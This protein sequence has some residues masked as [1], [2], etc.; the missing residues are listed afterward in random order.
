M[1][2]PVP[3]LDPFPAQKEA[4]MAAPKWFTARIR[5][6]VA[7]A[8]APEPD[9]VEEIEPDDIVEREDEE[10]M[11]ASKVWRDLD[12][13]IKL[14]ETDRAEAAGVLANLSPDKSARGGGVLLKRYWMNGRINGTKLADYLGTPEEIRAKFRSA[15]RRIVQVRRVG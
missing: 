13:Q 2:P 9:V 12:D 1:A 3:V 11:L 15:R 6:L 14:L 10:W 4:Q 8:A 5:P 7:L